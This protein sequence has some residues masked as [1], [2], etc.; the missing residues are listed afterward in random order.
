MPGSVVDK[1]SSGSGIMLMNQ[2]NQMSG[3]T[4]KSS[5]KAP[6][7]QQTKFDKKDD[8]NRKTNLIGMQDAKSIKNQ[9][10]STA[11][12]NKGTG[13]LFENLDESLDPNSVTQ[14]SMEIPRQSSAS[15]G[16]RKVKRPSSNHPK[17]P[18][19]I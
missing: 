11:V 10:K 14:N 19:N 8:S 16:N 13:R 5:G 18:V 3:G 2:M 4:N 9:I 17:D 12:S 7:Q 1:R 6:K 15:S